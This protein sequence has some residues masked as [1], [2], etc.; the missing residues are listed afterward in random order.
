MPASLTGL[1]PQTDGLITGPGVPPGSCARLAQARL[2]TAGWQEHQ[3][4]NSWSHFFSLHLWGKKKVPST[5]KVPEN[6]RKKR[7][8][9]ERST[10]GTAPYLQLTRRLNIVC[11]G[12]F[13]QLQVMGGNC[14][15]CPLFTDVFVQ[16]SLKHKE[17]NQNTRKISMRFT[18]P[19]LSVLL[20]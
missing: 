3:L 20:Y 11:Q 8:N 9:R 2:M 17:R 13:D 6:E 5:L 7:K 16:F 10:V 12:T 15:C 18:P 1:S 4:Q 19:R 14:G